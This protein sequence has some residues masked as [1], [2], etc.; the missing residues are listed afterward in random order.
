M[1]IN[2]LIEDRNHTIALPVDLLTTNHSANLPLA[3]LLVALHQLP[4][5][6]QLLLLTTDKALTKE[7]IQNIQKEMKLLQE[8]EMKILHRTLPAL[9]L[10]EVPNL[11]REPLGADNIY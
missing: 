4:P 3:N 7:V 2:M 11:Q 8:V 9:V 6:D 10:A 5:L 1:T